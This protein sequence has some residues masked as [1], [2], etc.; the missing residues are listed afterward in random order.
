MA[1]VE[2][3]FMEAVEEGLKL[4]KRLYF[5]KD[6]SVA[7][8]KPP[9]SMSK[10]PSFYLP[11]A[12]MVYAVI[13]DP[14]I[15]DNPDIPSYQPYVYGRCDPPALIPLQMNSVSM[16][17]D[18]YL[19][20]VFV[21]VSG[22]W[23]VHCVMGSKVCDCR[24]AV[25]MGEQGSILG[26]EIDVP[27][28]SYRTQL[29]SREDEKDE[30]ASGGDDGGFLR[31]DIFFLTIPQVDGGSN[32]NITISWSQKLL[33]HDGEFSLSV[34]FCFPE[35][36][37]PASKKIPRKEKMQLNV[38]PGDG[39]EV[40]CKTISHPLKER[41]RQVD[42]LSFK[43]ESDVLSWS[44]T[45]FSFSYSVP[46][47][48]ISGSVLL[49]SP[50]IE[51]T[52]QRE[53]FCVHLLPGIQQGKKVF[54][55]NIIY[56]V[57]ISSSM[58]GRPLEA[59]KKSLGAALSELT[60]EDMFNI[61]AFNATTFPFSSSIKHANLETIERAIQWMDDT[62]LVGDGTEISLA[63]D[64]AMEMLSDT[65]K[66]LPMIFLITDGSVEDER[67]IC[68]VAKSRL[69]NTKA[70]SPRI[71]TFGIGIYCNHYF[72]RM[73]AMIGQGHYEAA[74]NA[75]SIE[76]RL[77][78]L[79]TTA[80]STVF[81]NITFDTLDEHDNAEVHPINVPD[82]SSQSPLTISGRYSGKFPEVFKA[83]GIIAD[84]TCYELNL[85][86]YKSKAIPLDK[87]LALQQITMCTS[88]AWF[89]EDKQLE[90]KVAKLSNQNGIVSE[91]TSMAIFMTETL[92]KEVEV[93]AKQKKTPNK[94]EAEKTDPK[95][96]K[97][98][99]LRNIGIGFGNK[100]ATAENIPPGFKEPKMPE[101]AEVFAR[102]ASDCCTTMCGYCCCM[103]CVQACSKVNNQCAIV[104]TQLFTSLACFGCIACCSEIC[105]SGNNN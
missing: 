24:L 40:L 26:V 59:T 23:R 45:D 69:S 42:S 33:Y 54:A 63:L 27:K 9:P 58:Q 29:V 68:K 94:G 85:K 96:K 17:V 91:Y 71:H 38:H 1:A 77:Q 81:T 90:T 11:T 87:I 16:E 75:D 62:L 56:V 37:N 22:Q 95:P 13:T 78:K 100:K 7:P 93:I 65:Q 39:S 50:S 46:T 82:L 76:S 67:R 43:Y 8:P 97:L 10:N 18:C 74:Y 53:M 105:C 80:S 14:G 47:S 36:V 30:E 73:L 6:R 28:K 49:Q 88:E 12:P 66:S 19:D 83:R 99:V 4:S 15:V 44:N 3:A 61:I 41:K 25:P 31:P 5:G 103:C 92:N 55:R 84:M 48:R 79:I 101:P 102:A 104:F 35:Y 32:L 60:P 52:D 89:L 64:K 86:V 70:I 21:R 98:K 57:D 20:T 51:D 34:P 72:L 2:E